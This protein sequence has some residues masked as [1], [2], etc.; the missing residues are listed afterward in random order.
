MGPR[1]TAT[2]GWSAAPRTGEHLVAV[3]STRSR[4]RAA[5][6]AARAA[7]DEALRTWE[8]LTGLDSSRRL[9]HVIER[10]A[11]KIAAGADAGAEWAVSLNL[12]AIEADAWRW[13]AVGEGRIAR[14]GPDGT[15]ATS[16][17]RSPV[18]EQATGLRADG[19]LEPWMIDSGG[20]REAIGVG[21][22]IVIGSG[23]AIDLTEEDLIAAVW[24]GRRG[25]KRTLDALVRTLE[26]N[27]G[28]RGRIVAVAMRE[29]AAAPDRTAAGRLAGQPASETSVLFAQAF[30][31]G[32]L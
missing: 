32:F 12:A 23:A 14:A 10:A 30:L 2:A 29:A 16:G 11:E 22:A 26:E 24:D 31:G 21:T 13:A 19:R 17:R 3:A 18:G 8:L 27:D 6:A 1:F 4:E 25:A 20:R 9:A 15:V 28:Q 7:V 5:G